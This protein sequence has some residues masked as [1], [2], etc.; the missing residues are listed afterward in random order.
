MAV[1]ISL[2]DSFKEYL[3]DGTIDLDGHSF[4]V[5]LLTNSASFS[6][7]HSVLAD[8]SGNQISSGSGYTSGGAALT[9]VT[10]GQTGGTAKFDADD[11]AWTASGGAITA[12]KAALYDDTQSSPVKPLMAFID[13]GGVQTAN[14][15]AQFK[16]IW[17]AA[18]I[19]TLS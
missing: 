3:G 4:K 7:G 13:F 18:G 1:T 5:M 16:L 14:D 19:F 12:Y 6:A 9:G 15:G 11:A 2:Y 17:N 8:I 10:W